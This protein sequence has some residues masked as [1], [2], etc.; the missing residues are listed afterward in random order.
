MEF[1]DWTK[2][3][4]YSLLMREIK[5]EACKITILVRQHKSDMEKHIMHVENPSLTQVG[6]NLL[7]P[8]YY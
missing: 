5:G 1:E 6:E 4:R 2:N 7:S 8:L 3:Q